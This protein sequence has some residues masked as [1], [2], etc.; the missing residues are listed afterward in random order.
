MPG[1]LI[2]LLLFIVLPILSDTRTFLPV[3]MTSI[4]TPLSAFVSP[5]FPSFIDP[6]A[7]LPPYIPEDQIPICGEEG[8]TILITPEMAAASNSIDNAAPPT[9]RARSIILPGPKS[10]HPVT[11]LRI[12]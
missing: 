4:D 11:E 8:E 6:E 10:K 5:L 1:R 2:I 3:A 9:C 7:A 12:P